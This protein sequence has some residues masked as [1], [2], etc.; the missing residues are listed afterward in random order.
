M[1]NKFRMLATNVRTGFQD[2][3][4]LKA[5]SKLAT[6]TATAQIIGMLSIP[7]LTR[8]YS[9]E[10]YG[11]QAVYNSLVS[12]IATFVA[13]K[14][15]M[16]IVL[17]KKRLDS[18]CLVYISLIISFCGC[19]IIGVIMLVAK[20]E[21]AILLNLVE[22]KDWLLWLPI[23]ILFNM[24]YTI[25]YNFMNREKHYKIMAIAGIMMSLVNL[26]I[27]VLYA[28]LYPN[29]NKGLLYSLT[30]SQLVPTIWMI[31]IRRDFIQICTLV[32]IKEQALKYL[33]FPKYLIIG[34]TVNS[35]SLQLPILL[36][37]KLAT[38]EATGLFSMANRALGI[39]SRLIGA[40]VQNV[41]LKEANDEYLTNGRCIK[42]YINSFIILSCASV[43]LF[44]IILFISPVIIPVVLG[45]GWCGT[46]L[47]CQCLSFVFALQLI[48]SPLS[49]TSRIAGKQRVDMMFQFFRV[50]LVFL[51]MIGVYHLFETD[52]SLIAG[53]GMA[54]FF[55][56]S[57]GLY[58]S[59]TW[60]KGEKV[61]GVL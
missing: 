8:L 22:L 21:L 29:D 60:S 51:M 31:F 5:F 27:A 46:V 40:S 7:I 34:Q 28:L 55:L 15:E 17:P 47:Y 49:C 37:S 57:L 35:F 19:S 10:A 58:F 59:Y 23:T 26:F 2:K 38:P 24:T 48:Y 13:G 3:T 52:I 9:V 32:K 16:A 61:G 18:L 42:T 6:G 11:I 36:L 45:E 54:M 25:V 14:Y 1:N 4:L 41:Y 43:I 12:V 50:G 39:P 20:E 53:Y 30:F 56:Y 33:D 44:G